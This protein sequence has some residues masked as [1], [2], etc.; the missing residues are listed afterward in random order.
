[1][2]DPVSALA[3]AI[4]YLLVIVVFSVLFAFIDCLTCN[5]LK[6]I[7]PWRPLFW[8]A[9]ALIVAGVIAQLATYTEDTAS[10]S[11]DN[12]NSLAGFLAGLAVS[13]T[14][15]VVSGNWSKEWARWA[16]WLLTAARAVFASLAVYYLYPGGSDPIFRLDT[17]PIW[18]QLLLFGGIFLVF[19]VPLIEW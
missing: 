5:C 10:L 4:T 1:M 16:F 9:D 11:E 12:D 8:I 17:A 6:R 18:I 2:S 7:E 3:V 19:I 14:V 13:S 15:L